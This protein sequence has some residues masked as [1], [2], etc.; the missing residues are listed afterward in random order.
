[1]LPHTTNADAP[2]DLTIAITELDPSVAAVH[3]APLLARVLVRYYIDHSIV[4]EAAQPLDTDRRITARVTTLKPGKHH[5]H[6]ELLAGTREL[7]HATFDIF[8]GEDRA[9][10][11]TQ[12][13]EHGHDEDHHH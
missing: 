1:M 5:V 3:D 12:D 6:V 8:V 4:Y 9:P 13:H 10:S 7:G 11:A 2:F